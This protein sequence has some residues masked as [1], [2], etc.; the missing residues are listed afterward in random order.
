MMSWGQPL[1]KGNYG[2]PV[3]AGRRG[4]PGSIPGHP[5]AGRAKG[6]IFFSLFFTFDTLNG[7]NLCKNL[8]VHV[9][10]YTQRDG[11]GEMGRK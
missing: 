6:D 4:S 5:Q 11:E 1:G 9:C 3:K 2:S 10:I 8:S 7:Q